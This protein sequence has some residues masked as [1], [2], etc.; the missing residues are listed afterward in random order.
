MA[1]STRVQKRILNSNRIRIIP[2]QGFSWIDRRFLRD[3]FA[4]TLSGPELL[5]Y[6]FLCS[7][8]DQHGLSFYSDRRIGLILKLLPTSIDQ[9]RRGL[10]RNDLIRYHAPLYQVL[11]LPEIPQGPCKLPTVKAHCPSSQ[12]GV[13][14]IREILGEML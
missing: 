6:W 11:S 9:A 8:A 1:S 12:T 3:G 2:K 5:L 4:E 10:I 13:R 7:V 14:S